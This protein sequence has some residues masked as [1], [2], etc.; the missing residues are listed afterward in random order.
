MTIR[1]VWKRAIAALLLAFIAA[2]PVFAAQDSSRAVT[3]FDLA[4]A[5]PAQWRSVEPSSSMRLLQMSVPG[6]NGADAEV[7]VFFF[8]AGQGGDVQANVER[9]RSQ[10]TGADGGAVEVQIDRFEVADMPVTVAEL[11]GTYTRAVGGRQVEPL[12]GQTLVAAVVDTE[13]G[14]LFVQLRCATPRGDVRSAS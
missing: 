7:V 2:P 1:R 8:G 11:S 9:W 6:A 14:S 10:F 5:A 4:T 13:R 3:F 12:A